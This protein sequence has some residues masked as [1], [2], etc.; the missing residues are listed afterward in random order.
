[1]PPL[2]KEGK[3]PP[4]RSVSKLSLTGMD[5]NIS[6]VVA[7]LALFGWIRGATLERLKA[8]TGHSS[9]SKEANVFH[10]GLV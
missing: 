4:L 1:M 8:E 7:L 10:S 2:L 5:Q 6:H 3:S 9:Y